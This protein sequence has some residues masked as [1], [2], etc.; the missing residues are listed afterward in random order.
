V[1]CI[2]QQGTIYVKAI[3]ATDDLP[4][5]VEEQGSEEG[6][7]V[8]SSVNIHCYLFDANYGNIVLTSGIIRANAVVWFDGTIRVCDLVFKNQ[9]AGSNCQIVIVGIVK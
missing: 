7:T 8:L 9:T 4:F 2:L 3:T 6:E 1:G 5:H